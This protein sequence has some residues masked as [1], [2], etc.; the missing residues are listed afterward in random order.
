MNEKPLV[1]LK[2]LTYNHEK[3]VKE[4][5]EGAVSQTYTPLEIVISDDCSK[6]RTYEIIKE[7]VNQYRGPH[8]FVVNRNENNL[9]IAKNLKLATS[10]C[11]GALIVNQGGDDISMPNRVERVVER[12]EES[13]RRT[14]GFFSNAEFINAE[15]KARGPYFSTNIKYTRTLE[16]FANSKFDL[17]HLF[18]PYVWMLGATSAFE[19]S[20]YTNFDPIDDRVKQEDGVFSFRSL[21]LGGLEYIPE[22][23]VKYRRHDGA[24]SNSTNYKGRALLLATEYYYFKNQLSDAVKFGASETIIGKLKFYC[25]LAYCKKILFGIPYVGVWFLKLLLFISH[26]IR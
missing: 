2:I 10:L 7:F 22:Q 9:G 4:C 6:D 26:K 15:G 11:S 23:L 14:Y 1:S 13:G 8:K 20:I 18:E 17:S 21:L 19:K 16:Q 25:R 5:L 3:F 12:W 24:I